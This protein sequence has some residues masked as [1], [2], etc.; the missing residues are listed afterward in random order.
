[1]K[2]NILITG[3]SGLLAL[4]WAA[5]IREKFNVTLG[6]HECKVNLNNTK[7]IFLDLSSKENLT[8][9]LEDLEPKLVI[10]T[11]GLTNIE[12]CEANPELAEYI[13]AELTNNIASACAK[14]NIFMVYISTDHLFSG[15]DSFVDEDCPT[16]PVN[17][18]AKTKLK[19]EKYILDSHS[20]MLI[21][22]TNFYGWG[23]SYRQSFSDMIIKNLRAGKKVTLFKDI[24]YTPIFIEPLI[25]S[26]H[27]LFQK[28]I[29]GIFNIVGDDRISKFDFGLKLAKEFQ[30]NHNLIETGKINDKLSL[31]FRPHDMSLS[32]QKV[33][34]SLGRKIGGIDQHISKLK[35]QEV[36][37]H[38]REL[39]LL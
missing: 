37:G 35:A 39:A 9:A 36:S 1:M 33:T 19:A 25:Y 32:N 7:S 15:H 29:K 20:E 13:N 2:E 5:V 30:L 22:R 28:N 6:L 24:F 3:G 10:H 38:A 31:V 21:I 27:E 23:T 14:L 8:K 4:N 18:Y 11:A 17:V 26:V 12:L 34:K 16:S